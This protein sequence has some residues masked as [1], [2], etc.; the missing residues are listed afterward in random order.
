MT[1]LLTLPTVPLIYY[2]DEIGMKFQE[3]APVKEGSVTVI[4]RAGSRTP[5]Q[6]NNSKNAGFSDCQPEKLYL[7]VDSSLNYPNVQSE[8][9]DSESLLSF[10]RMIIHL[11]K[12]HG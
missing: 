3:N 11:K 8:K 12:S 5:M 6:W 1:L 9:N 7:P 4:N 2:G 10:T